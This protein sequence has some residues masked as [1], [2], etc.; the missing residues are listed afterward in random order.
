MSNAD[1]FAQRISRIKGVDQFVLCRH[2]GHVITHNMDDSDDLAS[3]ATL[4]GMNAQAIQS[5][6][7][8][9]GLRSLSLRRQG[10]RHCHIFPIDKYFLG[11]IQQQDQPS[12]EVIQDVQKFLQSLVRQKSSGTG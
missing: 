10:R 6:I 12:E 7:G 8:F 3:V 11:V 1:R 2:D 9:S 5:T 4:C